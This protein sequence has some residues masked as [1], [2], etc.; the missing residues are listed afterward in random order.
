MTR[1]IDCIRCRPSQSK[2]LHG[3]PLIPSGRPGQT[4]ALGQAAE[5]L[6][7]LINM[8]RLN[9]HVTEGSCRPLC[10]PIRSFSTGCALASPVAPS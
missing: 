8:C 7:K 2:L 4:F 9:V 10:D 5:L 3:S 6:Y 1:C